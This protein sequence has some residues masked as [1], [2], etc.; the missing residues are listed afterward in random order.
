MKCKLTCTWYH[1]LAVGRGRLRDRLHRCGMV[2][3]PL[4][5]LCGCETETID[6][7]FFRCASMREHAG[8]LRSHCKSL[9]LPFTLETLFTRPKLQLEVEEFLRVLYI[10]K[11]KETTD[12][13]NP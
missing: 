2:G 12:V 9:C 10:D 11:F 5:R 8:K 4:C 6:H 7:I 13:D 3:S 1:R